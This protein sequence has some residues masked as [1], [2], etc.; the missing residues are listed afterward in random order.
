M[1]KT[2]SSRSARIRPIV[3]LESLFRVVRNPE[4]TASGNRF[5]M[6]LE[7]RNSQRLVER[8]RE[9]PEGVCILSERSS[10]RS[11]LCDHEL[12]RAMP[13]RTLGRAYLAFCEEEEISM[14]GLAEVICDPTDAILSCTPEEA[15]IYSRITDQH[16]L[17]HVATGYSRD[18]VGEFALIAFGYEQI[19]FP[20]YRVLLALANSFLAVQLPQTRAFLRN[21]RERGR[22]ARWLL[23]EDWER[24]LTQPLEHVRDYLRLGAPPSYTRHNLIGGRLIPE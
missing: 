10:V 24:L 22:K 2:E 21:A 3:A 11:I 16:D 13:D 9:H 15:F 14:D 5:T 23:A 4:D 20:A 6:A 8:F 7:G 18:G 1:S 19:G 12:L 17:W